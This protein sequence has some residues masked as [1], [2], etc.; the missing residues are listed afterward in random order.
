APP[1][2]EGSVLLGNAEDGFDAPLELFMR[3]T[4][5]LRDI[6]PLRFGRHFYYLVNDPEMI[7]RV[8]VDNQRNY[9]KSRYH[10][11]MEMIMGRGLVTSDGD[12]WRRQ[13]RLAQP[14]FHRQHI[15]AFARTMSDCTR[16][17]LA[18]L[19]ER[20]G[21]PVQIDDELRRL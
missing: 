15:A 8:L 6:S 12:F 13:R 20:Q 17:T 1:G 11:G 9:K 21:Q 5:E 18:R 19:G 14:A 3:C 10:L 7:Q 4:T 16:D 2:P